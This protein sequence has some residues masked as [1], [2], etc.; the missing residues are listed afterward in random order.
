VADYS[1]IF[2]QNP[3]L[4][5][6][7]IAA[8]M[9]TQMPQV[10]EQQQPAPVEPP[11]P[12]EAPPPVEQA[13]APAPAPAPP[14]FDPRAMTPMPASPELQADIDAALAQP[15]GAEAPAEPPP[16]E[17]PAPSGQI[18][19]RIAPDAE[20][21][22]G[23]L[24]QQQQQLLDESVAAANETGD[25]FAREGDAKA[26][27]AS[28]AVKIYGQQAGV[29]D[30]YAQAAEANYGNHQARAARYRQMEDE[31]FERLQQE[32]PKPGHLKSIFNVISGIIGAAAGGEQGAA[33]GMLRQHVN[34]QAEEDAQERMAAQN[35][36]EVSGKI[37][38]RILSDS[39]NEFDAAAKLVAGQWVVASRHLEQIANE[40]NVPA[41]REQALRLSIQA[42]DQAR[43][44]LKQN[45]EAQVQQAQAAQAAQA[46][47]RAASLRTRWE[48]MPQQEL[49][50]L[51]R[52]GL[53][54][55]PQAKKL[56]EL[57][58]A[59]RE[60]AGD[61]GKPM[62]VIAGRQVA[63]PEV[64]RSVRDVDLS[65]FRDTQGGMDAL[66]KNL[67]ELDKLLEE[68]GT[69]A[70]GEHAGTMDALTKA[71]TGTIKDIKTLGTLDNGLLTFA[72]GLLGDPTSWYKSGGSVRARIK[73]TRASLREEL[74]AKA[75]NLG[76][77]RKGYGDTVEEQASKYGA[78]PTAPPPAVAQGGTP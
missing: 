46:K 36:I 74:E 10:Q 18:D 49:E 51:Q 62:P 72:E 52:A 76:L 61:A 38:D 25:S 21:P 71:A 27:A 47:A 22:K 34:R 57:Q 50:A 28:E 39:A 4:F 59:Q 65:K 32:P 48:E 8:A 33:I 77:G 29:A 66:E 42:K 73:A 9:G 1:D 63:N 60:A 19:M 5:A 45:V 55:A 14:S 58:K 12:V 17:A 54:P 69:E 75:E 43:G 31:D 37:Q 44:L 53:L 40:S 11:P 67:K 64:F 78:T 26:L 6:Q 15:L 16:A 70:Y 3:Q 41:F 56:A 20:R 30:R 23:S 2:R 7:A 35:R 24:G 68:H 13:P